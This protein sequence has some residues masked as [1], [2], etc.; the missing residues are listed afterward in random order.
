MMAAPGQIKQVR[1]MGCRSNDNPAERNQRKPFIDVG[2]HQ[3]VQSQLQSSQIIGNSRKL[4]NNPKAKAK[5]A[6]PSVIH[7][8]RNEAKMP[9]FNSN[10]SQMGQSLIG[11][12]TKAAAQV[13]FKA[14]ICFK[15]R[16]EIKQVCTT[17][18]SSNLK[19]TKANA[20]GQKRAAG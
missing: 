2:Q 1:Q 16:Q 15:S 10:E 19:T 20:H 11:G 3:L 12:S 14:K 13:N 17:Q 8:S 5:V 6:N 4:Q 9:Q 18:N 7:A